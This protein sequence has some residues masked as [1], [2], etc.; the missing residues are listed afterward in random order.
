MHRGIELGA[1]ASL[2][3]A[4]LARDH[5][6]SESRVF[7]WGARPG[8]AA[9]AKWRRLEPGD[10][11]K[12]AL[13]SS[14]GPEIVAFLESLGLRPG[15]EVEVR[16]KHPFDGPMVVRVDG[17]DRTMGDKVARQIF[18]RK[19]LREPTE[20]PPDEQRREQSA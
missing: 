15:V 11:A 2:G 4:Q 8:S 14:T 10:V 12:V 20:A 9:E 19:H 16:E 17:T 6:T 1:L 5:A 18:V 3:V 13:P 7:A